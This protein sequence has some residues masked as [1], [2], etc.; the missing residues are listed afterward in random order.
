MYRVMNHNGILVVVKI[1][2]ILVDLLWVNIK[3]IIIIIINE[4]IL[5]IKVNKF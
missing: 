5:T 2:K 1:Q 4:V 3:I